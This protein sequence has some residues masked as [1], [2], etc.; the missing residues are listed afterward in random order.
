VEDELLRSH[1]DGVSRVG[2]ALISRN[3]VDIL[4]E[5]VDDLSLP[6]VAPLGTDDDD[7]MMNHEKMAIRSQQKEASP[8]V[9]E[10]TASKVSS[11]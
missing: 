8:T 3:D 5:D 1:V 11:A 6:L 4:G 9:M 2:S 7:T 10:G